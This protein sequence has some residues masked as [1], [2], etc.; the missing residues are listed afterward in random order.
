MASFKIGDRVRLRA[1]PRHPGYSAGETGTVTAVIPSTTGGGED[2]CQVRLQS[3]ADF[4]S[5]SHREFN[6]SFTFLW[7]RSRNRFTV[8]GWGLAADSEFTERARYMQVVT[9]Y[10]FTKRAGE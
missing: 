4:L 6:S 9:S 3:Q 2:L 5:P 7:I 10:P 8:T 1:G